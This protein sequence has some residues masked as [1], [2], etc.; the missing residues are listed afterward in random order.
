VVLLV[1]FVVLVLVCVCSVFGSLYLWCGV[2]LVLGSC[3]DLYLWCTCLRHCSECVMLCWCQISGVGECLYVFLLLG[4]S[5][6]F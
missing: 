2:R 5:V 6:M 4:I 3:F 1:C